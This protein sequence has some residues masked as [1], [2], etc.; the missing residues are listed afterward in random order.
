MWQSLP[1]ADKRTTPTKSEAPG[2]ADLPQAK[3]ELPRKRLH[4]TVEAIRTSLARS[5]RGEHGLRYTTADSPV[6]VRVDEDAA[7]R[8]REELSR[9]ENLFKQATAWKRAQDLREFIAAARLSSESRSS[10][11]R[12]TLKQWIE[13]A[14]YVANE[15]DPLVH[16]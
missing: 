7:R 2:W 9:R 5:D 16:R 10:E 4:P 6:S 8:Q 15:S 12:E 11:E 1:T 3:L 14:T 13:W